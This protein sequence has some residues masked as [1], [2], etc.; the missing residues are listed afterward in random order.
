MT[1]WSLD[2]IMLSPRAMARGG[3]RSPQP[4]MIRISNQIVSV[5]GKHE[6]PG[7]EPAIG[8]LAILVR[9]SG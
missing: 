7:C 8:A 5:P 1:S 2:D 6:P 9:L 4:T 3:G